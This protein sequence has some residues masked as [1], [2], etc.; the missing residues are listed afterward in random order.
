MSIDQEKQTDIFSELFAQLPDDKFAKPQLDAKLNAK[1][2]PDIDLSAAMKEALAAPVFY[3]GLSESIFPGDSIAIVLQSDLPHPKLV[4]ELLLEQL[5]SVNVEPTD[6]VVVVT[7]RTAEQIGIEPALYEQPESNDPNGMPPPVFTVEFGF[8]GIN[9]QVHNLENP[10]GLAY[11]VANEGAEPIH[12]NRI[13]VDADV[14]LPVATAAPGDIHQQTD[15]IF[16]DFSTLE[17]KRRFAD[18]QGSFVSRWQEIEL[19]NDTLGAFFSIQ[20]VVA[21]GNVIRQVICGARK[22]ATDLARAAT[23]ELWTFDWSGESDVTVATI[24]TDSND[25]TWDDFASALIMASRVSSTDGPLVVWSELSVS[26][27]RKIRKACMS[28]F[29][30]GISGKL[31]KTMQHVAAIVNERPVYLRSR[32]KRN[33]VEELGLGFVESAQEVNRIAE[34]RS[35][36]LLIRDAQKC[37]FKDRTE[38]GAGESE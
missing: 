10:A 1:V 29:E 8:S 23:N 6:I 3:P 25:Q 14:I 26:P 4:L 17:I 13:M 32:L 11:L 27:D 21:P 30:D 34:S 35:N 36:G 19:A 2:E 9:F 24:E 5:S 18:G 20:L 28:Q 15:C 37:Q 16:P 22:D 7:A 12:V 33:V 31:T 38:S